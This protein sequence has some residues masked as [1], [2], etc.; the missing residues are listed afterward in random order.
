MKINYRDI[1]KS[2]L[3]IGIPTYN[4]ASKLQRLLNSLEELQ[5]P[6]LEEGIVR[7]LISDNCSSDS[8]KDVVQNHQ[9][10][11]YIDY[12]KNK[13]NTGA[14]R[15]L[16]K[17]IHHFESDYLL[18][19]CD[20]DSFLPKNLPKVIEGIWLRKPI[21]ALLNTITSSGVGIY[22][23]KATHTSVREILFEEGVKITWYIGNFIFNIK[24]KSISTPILN[25]EG[26][27]P[28]M[29]LFFNLYSLGNG[30]SLPY[31]LIEM[32]NFN[33]CGEIEDFYAIHIIDML[34]T[35]CQSYKR[36]ILEEN[37]YRIIINKAVNI[38]CYGVLFPLVFGKH[39]EKTK[40]IIK[41]L[42][43]HYFEH[44]DRRN[45]FFLLVAY[46]IPNFLVKIL[47][48]IN[49]FLIYH[50]YYKFFI[51]KFFNFFRKNRRKDDFYIFFTPLSEKST[52]KFNWERIEERE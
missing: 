12:S 45:K 6:W 48:P 50:A 14:N 42:L 15:N 21:F 20:D 37:D 18:I 41:K 10:A 3:T 4:R 2:F 43:A 52:W 13:E 39:Q 29:E 31:P 38:S 22:G 5:S 30:I 9:L 19:V 36:G 16:E 51:I 40:L 11:K 28:G 26:N 23:D 8:T 17:L 44:I 34:E 46:R 35:L 32:K 49:I 47:R 27:W 24:I 1:N 33:S 25:P 7:I